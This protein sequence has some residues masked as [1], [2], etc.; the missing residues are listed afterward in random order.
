MVHKGFK[1]LKISIVVVISIICLGTIVSI[2]YIKALYPSPILKH[3]ME[4]EFSKNKDILS[5]VAKYLE[6]QEY[7]N[8]YITSTDKKGE[9]FTSTSS[10]EVGKTI[11][12]S[13]NSISK[14]IADLFEKHNFSIITKKDNAIYFQRWS[15]RDFGRGVV[16]LINGELP[17]NELV[18]K[19]EP[20]NEE[21][22]YFYKEK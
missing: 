12:I 5:S 6:R 17:K 22:W 8:I 4:N 1:Y 14:H 18:T 19:I 2:I 3:N 15:N 7:T 16:Y 11:R 9:M 10:K 13:D 20:L 21:N